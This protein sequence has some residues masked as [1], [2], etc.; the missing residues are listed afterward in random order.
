MA[1]AFQAE[2]TPRW[3]GAGGRQKSGRGLP[4]SRTLR[5]HRRT[6]TVS[7][8][9]T[10]PL[11]REKRTAGRQLLEC[12]S[13]LALSSGAGG[14]GKSGRGLP[15]SRTLRAHRRTSSDRPLACFL[16]MRPDRAWPPR[17]WGQP[18]PAVL[19]DRDQPTHSGIRTRRSS[20]VI[21]PPPTRQAPCGRFQ[22]AQPAGT[23]PAAPD[24][25]DNP[26]GRTF[27]LAA[28]RS[29]VERGIGGRTA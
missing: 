12:A 3:P 4:R 19:R 8:T 26:C 14:G 13:H 27:D 10:R 6:Y 15:H 16:V 18:R 17:L 9:Q 11:S 5:A 25:L 7:S 20:S 28:S 23:T 29:I 1:T 22:V 21:R 24:G 2:A